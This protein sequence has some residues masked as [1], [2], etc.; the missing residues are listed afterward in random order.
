MRHKVTR[1]LC[2]VR[3][4]PHCESILFLFFTVVENRNLPSAKLGWQLNKK[5]GEHFRALVDIRATGDVTT[6]FHVNQT[7][8]FGVDEIWMHPQFVGVPVICT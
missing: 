3:V 6:C 5:G 8:Q 4:G 2:L 7:I 1:K